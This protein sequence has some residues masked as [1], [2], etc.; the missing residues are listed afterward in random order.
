VVLD[1]VA[2]PVNEKEALMNGYVL[3]GFEP[4]P[5]RNDDFMEEKVPF[6]KLKK[7][8]GKISLIDP[9][10]ITNINKQESTAFADLQA[11]LEQE[12]PPLPAE[13]LAKVEAEKRLAEG[14]RLAQLREEISHGDLG[15]DLAKDWTPV[16]VEMPKREPPLSPSLR[17]LP[18]KSWWQRLLGL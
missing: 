15:A 18:K 8:K 4:K 10:P 13:Y 1:V 12:P 9:T 11:S 14:R 3:L 16:D 17:K 7:K 5:G 2:E 6:S